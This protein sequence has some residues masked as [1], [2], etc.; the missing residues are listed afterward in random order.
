M[1]TV[2]VEKTC[3]PCRGGVPPLTA[4]EAQHYLTEVPDWALCDDGRT[5][6]RNGAELFVGPAEAPTAVV[7]VEDA[8][9]GPD[10]RRLLHWIPVPPHVATARE[11]VAWTFRKSEQTYAPEVE[12]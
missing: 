6:E 1:V 3:T 9:S 11:A 7:R 5:I 12:T 2:L 4:D 10:G 8:V